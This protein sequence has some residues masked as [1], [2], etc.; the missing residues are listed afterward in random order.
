MQPLGE[1]LQHV[2][3]LVNNSWAQLGL[4]KSDVQL[5]LFS[6][7]ETTS[8]VC[9]WWFAQIVKQICSVQYMVNTLK[10]VLFLFLS[11]L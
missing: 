11:G 8:T 4:N 10:S 6:P 3:G 5:R 9:I 1:F 7:Y 2:R